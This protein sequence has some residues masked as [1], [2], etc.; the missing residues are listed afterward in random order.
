MAALLFAIGTVYYVSLFSGLNA[1]DALIYLVGNAKR[2]I[3]L[4]IIFLYVCIV[5]FV[6]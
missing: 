3:T 1:S 4:I 6:L 5:F 2:E